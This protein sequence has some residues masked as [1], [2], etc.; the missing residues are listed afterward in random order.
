MPAAIHGGRA[1]FHRQ[2]AA[3]DCQ[4]ASAASGTRA[5]DFT[6]KHGIPSDMLP[7]SRTLKYKTYLGVFLCLGK[8]RLIRQKK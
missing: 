3:Q 8:E 2:R 7:P 1:V 5:A 4:A 6:K